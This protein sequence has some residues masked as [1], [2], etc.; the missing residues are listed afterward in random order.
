MYG[1]CYVYIYIHTLGFTAHQM[2]SQN[3]RT[4]GCGQVHIDVTSLFLSLILWGV[5]HLLVGAERA[6]CVRVSFSGCDV[7]VPQVVS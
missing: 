7:A 2:S 3:H 6:R 1:V 4:M 5:S